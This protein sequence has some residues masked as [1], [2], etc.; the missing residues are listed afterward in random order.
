[1]ILITGAT[2]ILRPSYFM[3]NQPKKSHRIKIGVFV[4]EQSS[5]NSLGV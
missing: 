4:C 2:T 3:Q 1:M 5:S